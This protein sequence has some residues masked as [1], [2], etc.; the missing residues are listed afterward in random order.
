VAQFGYAGEILKVDLA[1]GNLARLPTDDYSD[2]FLGGRGVAAKLYWDM[3]PSQTRAFD[4]ENCLIFATGPVTGFPRFA[5]CRCQVCGKSPAMEPECFSYANVGGRWGIYLKY[6]GYDGLVVQGKSDK[7]VYLYINNDTVEIRDASRLWGKTAFDTCDSLR[8][9][10]GKK[11]GVMAIGPAAEN[12]VAFATMLTDEGGSAS[13]GLGSVMGSKRLK[14]IVTVGDKR[15]VAADP[16]RLRHLADHVSKVI[17]IPSGSFPW[18][19]P[20]RTTA[21]ACYG[22]G[23]GC[24]RHTYKGDD[25]RYY[26][27]HCQPVDAYRR[28]VEKYHGGWNDVILYAERLFDGYGLETCVMQAMIDW[29]DSC[30]EEGILG[31]EQTGL[32]LA[33][34]GGAEFVEALTRIVTFREGFGDLLAQ[35]TLR[36]AEVIG[37][38]AK[39][40]AQ[41]PIYTR[42]GEARDYDPRMLLHHA[43]ILATEPRRSISALHEAPHM[44]WGW[45]DWKR[46]SHSDIRSHPGYRG[47]GGMEQVNEAKDGYLTTDIFRKIAQNRWGSAAAADYTTYEGKASAS[48]RIQDR[49]H[50]KESI[51]LCDPQ[52]PIMYSDATDDFTGDPTLESQIVSAVTGRELDETGLTRIGERIFNLIRAIQVRHGWEGRKG[53]R[54]L[55]HLHDEP[56]ESVFFDPDCLVPDGGGNITSRKGAVVGRGEFEK[57]K[58][59]YYELRGW[60]VASGLL[61]EAGLNSLELSDIA[62]DLSKRGLLRE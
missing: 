42:A 19:I 21:K 45:L 17:K 11:V 13:S 10:L 34:I 37:G 28:P 46:S 55:D 50:A 30:H 36:A 54:L 8:T 27:S 61:T 15:P 3:V 59:E 47:W 62:G 35:G 23:I 25:G 4:A 9:E 16:E 33:K 32:P 56:L 39:E 7:P 41:Y 31:D 57:M 52:W 48:K 12:L 5:S 44:L 1:Q 53:D 51:I 58:S 29:L 20:G 60:D 40:L 2:R 38:R 6:A 22:C 24:V 26:K 49:T 18:V 14:A 43:L